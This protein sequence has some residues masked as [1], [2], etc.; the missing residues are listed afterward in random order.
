MT[1]LLDGNLYGYQWMANVFTGSLT[2]KNAQSTTGPFTGV[3]YRMVEVTENDL[4]QLGGV[5]LDQETLQAF[6][7]WNIT[8]AAGAIA[9]GAYNITPGD[10]FTEQFLDAN[11][12]PKR[13][14]VKLTE[15]DPLVSSAG[16]HPTTKIVCFKQQ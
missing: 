12:Q 16:I 6:E 13:W 5:E 8:V 7:V 15:N 1:A 4:A 14:N 3:K 11:G 9:A 2:A 10:Q